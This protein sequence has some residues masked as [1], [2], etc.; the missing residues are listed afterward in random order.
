MKENSA[1]L[2]F[3]GKTFNEKKKKKYELSKRWGI[4]INT[5]TMEKRYLTLGSVFF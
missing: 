2:L 5:I 3:F 1:T 4:I